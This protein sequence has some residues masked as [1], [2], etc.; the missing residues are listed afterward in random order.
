LNWISL[1]ARAAAQARA[2]AAARIARS[3]IVGVR[4]R[5]AEERVDRVT[6][7]LLDRPALAFDDL[8]QL[9]ERLIEPG[10]QSL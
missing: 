4:D 2:P 10:L 9:G 1:L 5:C 8:A 7:V 3:A 6:N